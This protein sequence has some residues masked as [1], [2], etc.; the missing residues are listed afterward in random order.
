MSNKEDYYHPN[1]GKATEDLIDELFWTDM[2]PWTPSIDNEVQNHIRNE[3][4][5]LQARDRLR[6]KLQ[7]RR[8]SKPPST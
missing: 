1:Q 5:P 3:L 6:A 4:K 2:E 8:A 7:E